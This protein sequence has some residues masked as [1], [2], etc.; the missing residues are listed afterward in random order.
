MLEALSALLSVESCQWLHKNAVVTLQV[1]SEAKE[2]G[3]KIIKIYHDHEGRE[4]NLHSHKWQICTRK[5]LLKVQLATPAMFTV[6]K[7]HAIPHVSASLFYTDTIDK[8]LSEHPL[9]VA[10]IVRPYGTVLSEENEHVAA[11]CFRSYTA[12]QMAE[13]ER[14]ARKWRFAEARESMTGVD[15]FYH[16][17]SPIL[18]QQS[19][20]IY[21]DVQGA[22]GELHNEAAYSQFGSKKM[23]HIVL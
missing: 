22:M 4:W 15:M 18:Q 1:P 5:N 23:N 3:F 7:E 2:T 8:R 11:Q 16:S 10:S 21:S 14:L 9:V 19:T 17:L 12:Q 6:Q 13:A 20:A